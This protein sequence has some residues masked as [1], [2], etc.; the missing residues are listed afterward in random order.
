[1]LRKGAG[2]DRLDA[3]LL[4]LA[5][6]FGVLDLDAPVMRHTAE[7]IRQTLRGPTG[8]VYRYLGDTYYGGGEWILLT[9]WLGWYDASRGDRAGYHAARDWVVEHAMYLIMSE[10]AQPWN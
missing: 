1:M 8:G 10:A 2:D 6:P 9:C 4:W 3:S 5:L 7:A